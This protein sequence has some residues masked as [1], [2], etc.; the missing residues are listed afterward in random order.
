MTLTDDSL[1]FFSTAVI[2]ELTSIGSVLNVA[3]SSAVL[4]PAPIKNDAMTIENNN[5]IYLSLQT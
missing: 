1:T 4:V 5:F 2:E 3:E